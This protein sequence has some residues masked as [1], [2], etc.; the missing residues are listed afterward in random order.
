MKI[1]LSSPVGDP[2]NHKTW[3]GTALNL[4]TA[5]NSTQNL[6][7][8]FSVNNNSIQYEFIS[9]FAARYYKK[10]LWSGYLG[11][12][13]RGLFANKAIS[14][15]NQSGS[16]YTLH[17]GT[18]GLPFFKVPPNQNH[19]VL[20]DSTWNLWHTQA[21]DMYKYSLKMINDVEKLE[22]ESFNQVKHIFSISEY[23]KD[24][25]I[26][27]YGI[28]RNKITVV[29]TGRGIIEPY[30][31]QK[32]YANNKILFVAKGRFEDKGGPIVIEAFEKL[33]KKRPNSSLSI[34]GQ[35]EYSNI[36]NNPKIH[37]YG[38]V[39]IDEL[40]E[41]F[42]THSLFLMPATYEPW[43]LV[44]IEALSCKMP[45]VGLNINSFPELSGFGKYG[46]GLDELDSDKLV[47]IIDELFEDKKALNDMGEAGQSFCLTHFAW[48]ITA[49]KIISAIEN[50]LKVT[51]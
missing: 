2:Y 31:G 51:L 24:N 32:D 26:D 34:V 27:H 37:T 29:G 47:N 3:S 11:R 49:K 42:N 23:V 28:N 18:N 6:A 33:L 30:F 44:Y 20:I 43:G 9:A 16:N 48:D 41:L 13:I 12:I 25:L 36:T 7:N 5:L 50:D 38:F 39:S 21:T 15:T 4:L 46:V 22:V 14:L 1:N 40:Q 45:L 35:K 17:L 8:A 19:Y 10:Y